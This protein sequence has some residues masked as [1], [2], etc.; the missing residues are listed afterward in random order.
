MPDY[1][2]PSGAASA[3]ATIVGNV[4][5]LTLRERLERIE[6]LL[7]DSGMEREFVQRALERWSAR[8]R[9]R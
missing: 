2:L 1:S 7:R 8:R 4:D 9:A 3:L 6:A 5:Y